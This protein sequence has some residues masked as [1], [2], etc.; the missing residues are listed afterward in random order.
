MKNLKFQSLIYGMLLLF[1]GAPCMAQTTDKPR[2]FVLT[3]IE[4]EP[5]DAQS[6]VRFLLYSNQFDVEGL[7]ATTSTHLRDKTAAWRIK[8]IVNA[9]GKVRN[10]LLQHEKG[11]PTEEHLLST[12]KSGLPKYGMNAVGA[13][14]D[15]EGSESLI[16]VVDKEDDRP[17]WVT[18]WGGANVLAQALWKI[19]HTRTLGELNKFVAKLRVYTISDQ[20]DSGVW[21]RNEFPNLFYIVSPGED[22]IHSTWN[23]IGGESFR[24][25]ASGADASLA[26]N[27][28]LR[29]NIMQNH[30]P[31]GAQYPE[32]EY[33]MEG[34][35]PSFLGLVDN[36]LN[37]PDRP[38]FGGWGGRY[39]LY[40]PH[41]KPYRNFD[42]Q[43]PEQR[44]IWTDASDE[45]MGIDGRIYINNQATIWRW[46]EAFQNDFAARM[47]WCVKPYQEANHPPIV[48]VDKTTNI[49]IRPGESIQFDASDSTDPDGDTLSYHWF[50][51]KE[52]GTYWAFN[53]YKPL[54]ILNGNS[55]KATLE[56]GERIEL[57]KAQTTHL[58]LAVTDSGSPALTRYQRIIINILPKN[59]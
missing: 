30:G 38:D 6:L 50:N 9:Y 51:Y 18:V 48:K 43:A 49:T 15:S 7:I 40:K 14:N 12:I 13:G 34:D 58:I 57:S 31:L 29:K 46:R 8:E 39:E 23:G 36:G 42:H 41:F 47:D 32:V 3:D 5:D 16:N 10:N 54:T 4:N 20:D 55:A 56:I 2:V 27:P 1:I 35:T 21:M 28:W 37:V 45:V 19:R 22:Y 33:I 26:E 17:V 59:K 53:W 11:F 24:K 44:A 25:Y 52:A